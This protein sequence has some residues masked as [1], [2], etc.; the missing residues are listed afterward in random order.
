VPAAGFG[1]IARTEL[2]NNS[3]ALT[4]ASA[5]DT[6]W[7][8]AAAGTE[9]AAWTVQL[10]VLG[11]A[12]ADYF[13][14]LFNGIRFRVGSFFGK[15]T[16]ANSAD[17]TYT[18]PD[19]DGNITYETSVLTLNNFLFGGG[20]A[21]VKDAGFAVVPAANGGTGVSYNRISDTVALTNQ[22]AAIGSTNFAN[23][24]TAGTYRVSYYLEDTTLDLTAGTIQLQ[25]TFTDAA[26]AVTVSSTALPLTALGRTSGVFFIQLQSGNIA[27]STVL[28]GIVGTAKYAL[29]ICL[30]RLS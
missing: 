26:G 3:N 29:F 5:L 23:G 25:V 28:V 13:Q 16:H 4:D 8:S 15:L 17:R 21:L 20:G 7:T 30:E 14:V 22:G 2:D 12:L 6:F 1:A 18:F 27:Y 10:K 19:A 11:A 9:T 24:G